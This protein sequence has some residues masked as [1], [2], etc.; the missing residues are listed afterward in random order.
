MAEAFPHKIFIEIQHATHLSDEIAKPRMKSS[1]RNAPLKRL[2]GRG[3]KGLSVSEHG[4]HIDKTKFPDASFV[5]LRVF[6]TGIG[7]SA[8]ITR[9]VKSPNRPKIELG[10]TA[11]IAVEVATVQAVDGSWQMFMAIRFNRHLCGSEC[12]R[13]DVRDRQR[14]RRRRFASQKC[15]YCGR[16]S[17]RRA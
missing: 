14:D 2:T 17:N 11:P 12:K 9:N 10:R 3:T 5:R 8:T 15:P 1:A 4:P 13:A 16:K 7:K 6:L